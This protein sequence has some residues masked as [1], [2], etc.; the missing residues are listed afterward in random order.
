[1][2]S[3][4]R[5]CATEMLG[6]NGK[7]DKFRAVLHRAL[8][9]YR[10]SSLCSTKVK[11]FIRQEKIVGCCSKKKFSR[12]EKL[13]FQKCSSWSNLAKKFFGPIRMQETQVI[14]VESV[15]FGHFFE[16]RLRSTNQRTVFT[17]RIK[18]CVLVHSMIRNQWFISK[19]PRTG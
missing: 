10:F 12:R 15:D 1:M 4:E 17:D 11:F 18:R 14:G 7:P 5:R 6:G 9:T 19:P 3:T 16:S 13:S 8:I 2:F